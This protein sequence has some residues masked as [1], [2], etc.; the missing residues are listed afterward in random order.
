MEQDDN[1]I[2]RLVAQFT[3]A[4]EH[5]MTPVNGIIDECHILHE[6]GRKIFIIHVRNGAKTNAFWLEHH[7]NDPYFLP[8]RTGD[9]VKGIINTMDDNIQF[10][11][12]SYKPIFDFQNTSNNSEREA[13]AWFARQAAEKK[14]KDDGNAPS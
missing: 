12:H 4:A 5:E 3:R 2:A 8:P 11:E 7:Q 14:K 6:G 1:P 13:F 10:L 9:Q